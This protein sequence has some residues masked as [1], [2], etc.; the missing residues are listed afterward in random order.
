MP[1]TTSAFIVGGVQ[2]DGRR[3]VTETHMLSV[4]APIVVEYLAEAL[5]DYTAIMTARA[6]QINADLLER[7]CSNVITQRIVQFVLTE[8]SLANLAPRFWRAVRWAQDNDKVIFSGLCWL[9]EEWLLAGKV[10]DAQA[11][12]SF[13]TEFGR[14]LSATQW[15][16]LRTSRI[17]P[18]HDRFAAMLSDGAL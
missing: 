10:T 17:Q 9:L 1:V 5:A 13:N 8:A 18:A 2:K 12:S 16:T 3:Y 6:T 14:A 7:E 4:G 11:R 15:T